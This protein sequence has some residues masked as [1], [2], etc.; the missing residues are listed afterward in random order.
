MPLT[1]AFLSPDRRML[2]LP[3]PKINNGLDESL[4]GARAD[5]GEPGRFELGDL[6]GEGVGGQTGQRCGFLLVGPLLRSAP[7]SQA[8]R[9]DG[10]RLGHLARPF[11]V[12]L[13][14]S[15]AGDEA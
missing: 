5:M 6:I 13:S 1:A 14:R 12:K 2:M 3:A 15:M 8:C 10:P 7:L 11:S 9:Y 4:A